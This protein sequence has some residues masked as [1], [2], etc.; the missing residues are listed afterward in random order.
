MPEQSVD[1]AAQ[2]AD[3]KAAMKAALERKKA[4]TAKANDAH[5]DAARSTGHTAGAHA[6]KRQFRR[7]SGG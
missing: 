1:P 5:V 2:P 3:P 4:A 7:K 6:G